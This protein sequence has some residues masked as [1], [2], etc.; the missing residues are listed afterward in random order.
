M[1]HCGRLRRTPE[2]GYKI[3]SPC[4]SSGSG[5]LISMSQPEGSKKSNNYDSNGPFFTRL[6]I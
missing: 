4:E 3:S 6:N 5:E 2:Y 1:L